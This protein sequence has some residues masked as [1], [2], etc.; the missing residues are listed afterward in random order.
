[1]GL[2]YRVYLSVP[3]RRQLDTKVIYKGRHGS[4]NRSNVS[5]DNFALSGIR[6]CLPFPLIWICQAKKI[7]ARLLQERPK[8]PS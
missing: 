3:L 2:Q 4:A 8:A 5:P 7:G 1:M 6:S